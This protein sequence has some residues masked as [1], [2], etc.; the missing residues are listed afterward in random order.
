ME[1]PYG[2]A[3]ETYYRLDTAAGSIDVRVHAEYVN[4][5]AQDLA[6]LPVWVM[7]GAQDIVVKAGDQALEQKLTPGSEE[8]AIAG[9]AEVTLPKPLKKNLRVT[10][11]T[12]YRMPSRVGSLM[13]LEPGAIE[14]PFIGQGPGSFVFIDVPTAGDNVLDPGCLLAKDQPGDV[15]S[16]GLDRW[17]CGDVLLIALATDDPDQ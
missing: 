4:L 2:V 7:P 1:I 6:T 16:A 3:S 5:Q 9:T 14:T 11:D 10:L 12:T 17:V 15:K 8:T 13:S